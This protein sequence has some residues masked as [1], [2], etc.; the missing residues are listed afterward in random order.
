MISWL[1]RKDL[2]KAYGSMVVCVTK[3]ADAARLLEVQNSNVDVESAFT[4]VFE[5]RG[6][7]MECF[8]C[9]GRGHKAFSCVE[10]QVCGRC[11]QPGR[12]H[13]ECQAEDPR[14]AIC[15]GPHGSPSRQCRTLYPASDV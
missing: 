5:P 2:P 3:R 15:G 8:K 13:N 10:A 7:P 4:R 14:C 9:L 6:G 11:A 12:R 1:S